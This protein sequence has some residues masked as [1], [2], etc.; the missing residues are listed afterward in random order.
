[1][2]TED[3]R[4]SLAFPPAKPPADGW[5]QGTLPWPIANAMEYCL[6][7]CPLAQCKKESKNPSPSDQQ[8]CRFPHGCSISP[9]HFLRELPKDQEGR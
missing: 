8:K 3:S 9:N 4:S 1:M 6:R 7:M 5:P 2:C